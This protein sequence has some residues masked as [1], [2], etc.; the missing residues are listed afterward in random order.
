MTEMTE[1][2]QSKKLQKIFIVVG[3][4][5]LLVTTV[6]ALKISKPVVEEEILPKKELNQTYTIISKD[7]GTLQ[8]LGTSLEQIKAIC[9][10]KDGVNSCQYEDLDLKK[11]QYAGPIELKSSLSIKYQGM[12]LNLKTGKESKSLEVTGNQISAKKAGKYRVTLF[13]D[14]GGVWQ[15]ILVVSKASLE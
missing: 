2:R 8:I 10:E 4:I 7:D 15:F 9:K 3:V 1:F 14:A 13:G 12:F 5:S 11:L 6:L